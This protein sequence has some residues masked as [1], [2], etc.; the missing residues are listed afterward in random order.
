VVWEYA[1]DP[2]EI[3]SEERRRVG[4]RITT[5]VAEEPKLIMLSYR[6]VMPKGVN[7]WR[8]AGSCFLQAV[9][10]N[11][12]RPPGIELLQNPAETNCA[13]NPATTQ[14]QESL[15]STTRC[16]STSWL[17]SHHPNHVRITLPIRG[18]GNRKKHVRR[19]IVGKIIS[20]PVHRG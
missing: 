11:H 5:R 12:R 7:H 10:E 13:D 16:G 20:A 19:L 15:F 2:I 14:R 1:P 18:T 17:L 9:N 8:P 4:I 3:L 6:G